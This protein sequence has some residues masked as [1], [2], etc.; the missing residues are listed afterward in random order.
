MTKLRLRTT[1]MRPKSFL[2]VMLS[3]NKPSSSIPRNRDILNSIHVFFE[4]TCIL[5]NISLFRLKRRVY[6]K[7]REILKSKTTFTID[8]FLI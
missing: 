6:Y 2:P 8:W 5:F 7:N 1:K 4:K 3:M